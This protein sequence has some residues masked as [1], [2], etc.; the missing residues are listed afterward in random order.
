MMNKLFLKIKQNGFLWFIKRTKKEFRNPTVPLL[1]AIVDKFLYLRKK[2][3][4]FITKSQKDEFLYAVYD[5]DVNAS[6][7][8]CSEFLIDAEYEANRNNK[9][10]FVV[11]IVPPSSDQSLGWKEYDFVIDSDS[12]QWRFQNIVIS[13]T[14]LSPYCKGTYILPSR[15]EAISFVKGRD[16]YPYLYD[17][18][19]LRSIDVPD[20]YRKFD[21]PH[22]FEGFRASKQGLKYIRDWIHENRIVFP[23]VTITIRNNAFDIVRNSN[24]KEWVRFARYLQ[25]TGYHPVVIPDTDN[26][27]SDDPLFEGIT[28]FRECAWNMGLRM[29]LYESAFLNLFVPNGCLSIALYNYRCSYICMNNHPEGSIVMTEKVAKEL[30]QTIGANHKFAT[31]NQ[32]LS[33]KP[34][35]YDN[36]L[37]EFKLFL[38]DNC[39]ENKN[40]LITGQIQHGKDIL[41]IDRLNTRSVSSQ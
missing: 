28:I 24:I 4:C 1:K 20:F 37:E 15:L 35:S 25:S 17:G 22:L 31:P 9:S 29:A 39:R 12:K 14:F 40:G 23:V 30:G 27:F 33:Y 34:D 36:I 10:G 13:L 5:L 21:R 26:A 8:N 3:T 16:V 38:K 6:T 32:R 18:R 41:N 11:V 7:Y 19:N 2:V